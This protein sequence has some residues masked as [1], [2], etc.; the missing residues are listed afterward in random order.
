MGQTMAFDQLTI[1]EYVHHTKALSAGLCRNG[2]D[3]AAYV[4][5]VRDHK[6]IPF[7]MQ[8]LEKHSQGTLKSLKLQLALV[9]N[10]LTI[11]APAH[12]GT[13]LS[14]YS[15]SI[16]PYGTFDL[17]ERI[18]AGLCQFE[19][20]DYA[21]FMQLLLPDKYIVDSND[22]PRLLFYIHDIQGFAQD[23]STNNEAILYEMMYNLITSCFASD[24]VPKQLQTFANK[25]KSGHY[26]TCLETLEGLRDA[27]KAYYNSDSER[28]GEKFVRAI[29]SFVQ[30]HAL[31][32]SLL[33]LVGVYGLYWFFYTK[34][35]LSD[36]VYKTRIGDV[37]FVSEAEQSNSDTDSETYVLIFPNEPSP[38]EDTQQDSGD[39]TSADT[40]EVDLGDTENIIIQ[41]GDNLFRI[42]LRY[43]GDG[44][45]YTQLAKYNN[46]PNPDLI[47]IGMSLEIP[48]LERL[49]NETQ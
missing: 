15:E 10:G 21:L 13:P 5:L 35:S 3:P 8:S 4:T 22:M 37:L 25:V 36:T 39:D 34:P 32:I 1:E 17:I 38:Q 48:P 14:I 28:K 31:L 30:G 33:L 26:S 49:L 20:L 46:I 41:P 40:P 16:Q 18:I 12:F 27:R 24:Y 11:Y 45:Y 42:S 23:T 19:A 7:I 43:Y 47:P 2:P 44:N 6:K 29:W 9:E